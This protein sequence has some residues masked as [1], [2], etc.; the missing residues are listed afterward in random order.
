MKEKP[1]QQK[2]FLSRISTDWWAV[3]IGLALAGLVWLGVITNVPW[4]LFDLL[5]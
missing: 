2:P 1:E 3:N 5:K 4:P